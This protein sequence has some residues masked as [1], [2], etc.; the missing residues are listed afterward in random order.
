MDTG[1]DSASPFNRADPNEVLRPREEYQMSSFIHAPS[2]SF[3]CPTRPGGISVA[4][5][6]L[7]SLNLAFAITILVLYN[8]SLQVFS[9]LVHLDSILNKVLHIRQTDLL[10]LYWVIFLMGI[11][12]TLVFFAILRLFSRTATVQEML[13]SVAG[14]LAIGAAPC[15]YILAI[16]KGDLYYGH[17]WALFQHGRNYEFAIAL[18][19]VLAYVKDWWPVP[20]TGSILLLLAHYVFWFWEFR[21]SFRELIWGWGGS[22][23]VLPVLGLAA[24]LCWSLYVSARQAE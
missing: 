14:F 15:W 23:A 9:P 13:R 5:E 11:A 24:G 20:A 19:C 6:F 7:S 8:I 12:L 21:F 3:D 17:W 2:E 22:E 18:A 10:R 1:E 16:Y 4:H